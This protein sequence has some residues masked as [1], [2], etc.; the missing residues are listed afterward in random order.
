M[1][2]ELLRDTLLW[3]FIINFGLMIWW[4]LWIWLAHD[5][6]Y[7]MHT[8]WF[9]MSVEQFDAIH[10]TGIAIHKILVIVF[11]FVPYIALHIVG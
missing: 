3:C 10:Y 5:W 7:R 11:F 6:V 2:I 4:F 1:N 9:K 8:R